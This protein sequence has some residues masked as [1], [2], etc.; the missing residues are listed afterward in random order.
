MGRRRHISEQPIG[1]LR[2]AD[3]ILGWGATIGEASKGG[4]Y[5]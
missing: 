2:K 3:L 1:R 5:H 4:R